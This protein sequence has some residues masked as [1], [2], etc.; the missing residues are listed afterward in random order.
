AAELL[1]VAAAQRGTL[2]MGSP[3]VT[4]VLAVVRTALGSR[5]DDLMDEWQ[6][7]PRPDGLAHLTA[8]ATRSAPV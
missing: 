5:A 7:K 4:A 2:D 1:G 6:G 3:D 8:F